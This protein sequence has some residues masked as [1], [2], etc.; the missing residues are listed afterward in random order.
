MNGKAG[1]LANRDLTAPTARKLSF[2]RGGKTVATYDVAQ[3]YEA[4]ARGIVKGLNE[5]F[6]CTR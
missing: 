4:Y 1:N 2:K 6:G 5:A 3:V